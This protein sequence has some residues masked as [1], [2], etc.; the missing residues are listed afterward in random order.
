MKCIFKKLDLNGIE[1]YRFEHR[2]CST[3]GKGT[4]KKIT[5]VVTKDSRQFELDDHGK[6]ILRSE[7][8]TEIA[9]RYN[10]IN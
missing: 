3:Y 1:D 10:E 5:L 8:L 7:S 9:K 4:N 2:V 6:V